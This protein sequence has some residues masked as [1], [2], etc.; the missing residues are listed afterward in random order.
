MCSTKYV[1]LDVVAHTH[2]PSTQ[3]AKARGSQILAHPELQSKFRM[4]WAI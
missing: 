2:N 1:K 3:E 4:V